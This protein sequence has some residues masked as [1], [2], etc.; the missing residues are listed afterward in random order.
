MA[1]ESSSAEAGRV[2]Q[3]RPAEAILEV[4]KKAFDPATEQ[5]SRDAFSR[6]YDDTIAKY[7]SA[8]QNEP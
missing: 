2:P 3:P 8:P 4:A 6:E 7:V 1:A 5:A